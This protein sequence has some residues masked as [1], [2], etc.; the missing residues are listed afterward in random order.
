MEL[1]NTTGRT[2][3]PAGTGRAET[4]RRGDRI[5]IIDVEGGQ[6]GDVFAFAAAD[7][8]EH[9]S[10]SHTR[11]ATGRL[12]PEVGEHF[13]TTRRRP[14]LTLVADT[15]PGVHDMLIAACDAERYRALG[16]SEHRSCAQNLRTALDEA[17]LRV[18]GVPQ[19]VNVF[20]NIPV[21]E[22]GGLSWLPAVTRPGDAVEFEAAMDC[23]LVVSACPMDLNGINGQRPTPLAV[24]LERV[25]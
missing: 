4:L 23:V 14:I 6:V 19:P 21:A 11:T 15:S 22:A 2:E 8:T 24:E 16:V 5:R 3:V 18:D 17:G 7:L 25:A 10:A 1:T 12:F 20:M 13:L 9:L